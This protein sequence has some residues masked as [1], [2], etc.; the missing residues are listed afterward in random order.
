MMRNKLFFIYTIIFFTFFIWFKFIRERL[1]KNIPFTLS[2]LKTCLLIFTCIILFLALLQS[3]RSKN[4]NFFDFTSLIFT[5]MKEIDSF[6]KEH[7]YINDYYEIFLVKIITSL[8]EKIKYFVYLEITL[9]III[10]I[11]FFFDVFYFRQIFF[12]YKAV[13]LFIIIYSIKYLL[14]S[15]QDLKNKQQNIVNEQLH[16]HLQI[17][18]VPIMP[19]IPIEVFI[20]KQTLNI[21]QKEEKLIYEL[22]P[23]L[24]YLEKKRIE[25]N[26]K[27]NQQISGKKMRISGRHAIN[28]ILK[29]NEGIILFQQTKNNTK[30][31]SNILLCIYLICWLY[32]LYM[33]I[34]TL[35]I[36][37]YELYFL[38]NFQDKNNPFV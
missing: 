28:F 1:P 10:G 6:I 14:Y 30:Y 11:I 7:K 18:G 12:T 26:L 21:I 36:S 22:L 2:L 5:P 17:I 38:K 20:E 34:H 16:I 25:L 4:N 13:Y 19:K 33:S 3:L 9:R 23:K 15:L 31:I 37:N 35:N 24:D 8:V 27:P 29:L 32:I